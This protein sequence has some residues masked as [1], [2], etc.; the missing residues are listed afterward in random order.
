GH[1]V[2][3]HV[4]E[5]D[6]V[7]RTGAGLAC[8]HYGVEVPIGPSAK[9]MLAWM[10]GYFETNWSVNPTW[11]PKFEVFSEHPAARGLK[12]FGIN[13]EWYFHMRFVEGMN[14]VTPIL[15]AVAPDDTMKRPDG[16]H[17]GNPAVR[18]A[19]A[20]GEPQ[21]VAWAYQRGEDYANGRGF[22]FTGLH[23]HWNWEDDNFRK[24]VLNGVAWTA[25]LDI[26]EGGVE[27]ARPTRE[28]LEANALEHGGEQG[29][30]RGK[31]ADSKPKA[32][33]PGA[34]PLYESPIVAHSNPPSHSVEID[35]ELPAGSKE[36][37]LV[38]SD[39]GDGISNDWAA[40]AEPRLMMADGSEKNLTDLNWKAASNGFGSLN[41]NANCRGEPIRVKGEVVKNGI[42]GH[43]NAVIAYDLPD[44]ARR[45][46]ARGVLDDG[47]TVRNGMAKTPTSVRFAVFNQ[48]GGVADEYVKKTS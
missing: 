18:E 14:G 1:L 35:V 29:R 40:W 11:R 38:I 17:E 39:A 3:G 42:G 47:G 31:A 23:F 19:V 34:K 16:A 43:A 10:G 33:K 48:S 44:G 12:A 28:A 26:P 13:D 24:T 30:G 21:H 45:F 5:F 32:A 37:V 9:G 15:S 7:M 22:G 8:L 25:G 46:K 27:T 2:N 41:K 4:P 6:K 20:K 36:L